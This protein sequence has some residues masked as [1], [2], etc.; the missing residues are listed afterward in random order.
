MEYRE[1]KRSMGEPIINQKVDALLVKMESKFKEAVEKNKKAQE[2]LDSKVKVLI[3]EHDAKEEV[4]EYVK[5]KDLSDY[6][7][8]TISMPL[9]EGLKEEVIEEIV[10][11][12]E[13]G[14]ETKEGV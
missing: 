10:K 14:G 7:A 12:C 5:V 4:K 13:D 9:S 1:A 6:I 3:D 11:E 8:L 2:E